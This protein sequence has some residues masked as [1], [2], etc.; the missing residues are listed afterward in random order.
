MFAEIVIHPEERMIR[1]HSDPSLHGNMRVVVRH[2][3][4]DRWKSCW[5]F[6]AAFCLFLLAV[7]VIVIAALLVKLTTRGPA[8]YSQIRLG[9]YGQQ[10]WILKLRTMYHN[11]ER[12]SG[13]RWAS[14]GDNRIT[15]LGRI[16]RK[17]HIDEL[18]QLW[19]VL[20]GEMSLVGP[21]PER[22]EFTPELGRTIS[23]YNNRLLIKPGLTGLA[24]VQLPPDSDLASV[25]KKL[26]F[27][28]YYMR[29]I[30]FTLDLRIIGGTIL[31]LL[32]IPPETACWMV[33][34]PSAATVE[35]AE[36]A[37]QRPAEG[38][39]PS[40]RRVADRVA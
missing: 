40:C 34:L 7:P 10:F 28:L 21:R 19:N 1:R 33:G 25:R 27:D 2:S 38:Q 17:L 14:K 36:E 30:H 22:P 32:R 26:R 37:R 12:L 16:L 5:D 18:P 8:F 31:Y 4:Y 15:P 29:N 35:A 24:Q 11:C 9:R 13:A 23:G 6:A 39:T 3:A 20:R